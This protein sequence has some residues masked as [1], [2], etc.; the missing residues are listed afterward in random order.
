M[1]IA[2]VLSFLVFFSSQ[3]SLSLSPSTRAEFTFAQT[4]DA[5]RVFIWQRCRTDSAH[6]RVHSH[7]L[8]VTALTH[9]RTSSRS[10]CPP[11][12]WIV[13]PIR[14]LPLTGGCSTFGALDYLR[15]F[16]VGSSNLRPVIL[17]P[18]SSTRIFPLSRNICLFIC[19]WLTVT[20]CSFPRKTHPFPFF[21][22][23][24]FLPSFFL[25]RFRVKERISSTPTVDQRPLRRKLQVV[26]GLFDNY[27][28]RKRFTRELREFSAGSCERVVRESGRGRFLWCRKYIAS[29][30]RLEKQKIIFKSG[31]F[32]PESRMPDT[33]ENRT[34][35]L[36]S[37]PYLFISVQLF[38]PMLQRQKKKRKKKGNWT[39]L[40]KNILERL[41]IFNSCFYF[42]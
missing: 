11:G 22:F 20:F 15:P 19:F 3:I 28:W 38:D 36:A 24:S 5:P 10:S 37:D 8:A 13:R 6:A 42:A 34:T 14:G 9:A 32:F 31:R 21:F 2:I 7:V 40:L 17:I 41:T 30:E 35:S 16:P 26:K 25:S 12:A 27:E 18:I 1:Y 4:A 39:K 23:L 33:L 29:S